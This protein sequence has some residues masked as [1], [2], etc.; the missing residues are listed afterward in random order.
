MASI[1]AKRSIEE[2]DVSDIVEAKKVKIHSVITGLSPIKT[3]KTSNCKYFDGKISDG[4][5]CV[6]ILS[7]RL[8]R[9]VH[10]AQWAMHKVR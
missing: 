2:C 8:S 10:I 4:K 5:K 6:R 9:E 1:G 7:F 3:G